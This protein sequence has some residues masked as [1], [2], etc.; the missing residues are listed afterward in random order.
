MRTISSPHI[1]QQ[2]CL[3]LKRRGKTI[4]VVPTMGYLHEGHITLLRK[5]RKKADIVILT[6]FVNPKQ[7]GPQ[8]DLS[9]YPRDIKG[10]LKKAKEAGVDYVFL[11]KVSA[12]YPEGYQTYVEVTEVSQELCGESRP[13]HF[14]GVV[15]VV[16]KLFNLTQPDYAFFGLKDFQQF[17]AV[18]RMVTDLNFP[19]KI[20]GVPTVREKDGLALSSRNVYLSATE[21]QAA[22]VIPRS[23]QKIK[24]EVKKGNVDIFYLLDLLKKEM[25]QESLARIDYISCMNA[26][27]IQ[28]LKEYR[29]GKTL[30]AVAVF[31]GKTRLIDN[32][33]V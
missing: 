25:S 13:G 32:L 15:T 6:L 3:K 12:L 19:I 2:T 18:G 17:V 22:L 11:P 5:A 9:R 26:E 24:D 1:I 4:A 31:I 27:T 21:R 29:R 10:D 7:F 33:V 14:K 28:P 8:E 30:F 23:F 20:I 16:A